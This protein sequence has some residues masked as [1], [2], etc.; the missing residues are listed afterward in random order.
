MIHL[1]ASGLGKRYRVGNQAERRPGFLG[2]VASL[3]SASP[4]SDF[5]ALRGVDLEIRQGD[6][7]GLLGRN[8]AGKSTL[9]KILSRITPPTEGRVEV[10]GRIASLLEVGTGFHP[11]LTGREN[12]FLNGAILGMTRADIHKR[13]EEIIEFAEI[14][15]FL[16]TPVKRYSSG[17]YTRLAFAV[18]AHLEP[19]ILL[20]DE[21][22]AVGDF[23]FQKKCLGKMDSVAKEGRT[24]VFVSHNLGAISKLFKRDAFFESGALRSIGQTATVLA[25]YLGF[26][27]GGNG[28]QELAPVSG[29]ASLLSLGLGPP[30]GQAL[31]V[32]DVADGCSVF[33]TYLVRGPVKSLELSITLFDKNGSPLFVSSLTPDGAG[34]DHSEGRYSASVRLPGNFLAP[35]RYSLSAALHRPN[36]QVLDARSDVLAWTVE[37][38]GSSLTR[39]AGQD[40][41]SIIVNLDWS[42]SGIEG[43]VE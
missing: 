21:V 2:G 41:G 42:V 28:Y 5:W 34:S 11:E 30:D 1:R 9:L 43:P 7:L 35:G 15:R 38:T 14:G 40:F 33:I 23:A 31:G 12:V 24:V 16:D 4:M 36:V 19:D 37:D 3:L 10:F 18:A 17:M 29:V 20:V 32:V 25:D 27:G 22:L 8:G 26:A 6:T 39:Y 13:F